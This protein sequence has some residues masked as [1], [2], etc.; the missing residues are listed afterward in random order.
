MAL[1]AAQIRY[2]RNNSGDNATPY[3]ISPDDLQLIF[4]DTTMGDG[5]LDRTIVFVL[6]ERLG[7][8]AKQ[9][10]KTGDFTT[11]QAQQEFEH[12]ERL[13]IRWEGKTGLGGLGAITVGVIDLDLDEPCPDG[14]ECSD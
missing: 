13:L 1:T 6:Q 7:N 8:A 2:V 4:D 5:D 11:E 12:I 14:M 3:E 10:A 9:V